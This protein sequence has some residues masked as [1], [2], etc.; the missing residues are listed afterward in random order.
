[1]KMFT[2][3]TSLFCSV[4]VAFGLTLASAAAEYPERAVTMVVGSVPGSGPDVL[5]RSM[6]MELGEALGQPIVVEN[7][8]GAAGNVAAAAV[9][10]SEPDGYEIFIGTINMAIATWLPK[11]PPF[12]PATDFAIVGRVAS[13][14]NVVVITPDL[15]PKS[16]EEFVEY[17]RSRPGEI[18]Y[19]SPGVGSLQHMGTDEMANINGL[20][21]VHVP[22]R[23]GKASTTAV[24]AGEVEMF[25]AGMPP[26]IPQIQAG[27]LLALAVSSAE[28]F[29]LLPGV[30]TL[31]NTVMPGYSAEAWYGLFMAK[32]TPTEIVDIVNAAANQALSDPAVIERFAN[33]GAA[34]QTSTPADFAAFVAEESARWKKN[35]EDLGLAGTR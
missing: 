1:M 31:A 26:A 13:I 16:I 29:P 2:K 4:A 30:P 5:A 18:N 10:R 34:V 27:N 12:D 17:I 24:L 23:G 15:G 19:S 8:P 21:M 28:E 6:A 32:E 9:S 22:Y 33:A 20:E 14:P 7:M 35:L 11:E 25:M 3:F